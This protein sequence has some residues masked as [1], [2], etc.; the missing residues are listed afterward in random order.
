MYLQKK[1]NKTGQ[2]GSLGW[3]GIFSFY[4]FSTSFLSLP[5]GHYQRVAVLSVGSLP[6]ALN[7]GLVV[8]FHLGHTL[9]AGLLLTD[10]REGA[11]RGER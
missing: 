2:R 5:G 10:V 4:V 1:K 9:I 8:D 3:A 11:A 7:K 6:S